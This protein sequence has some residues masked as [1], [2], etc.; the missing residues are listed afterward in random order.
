MK[1]FEEGIIKLLYMTAA[2]DG[3]LHPNEL[4]S[5]KQKLVTYPWLRTITTTRREKIVSELM[6]NNYNKKPESEILAEINNIIPDEL[7]ATAYALALEICAKDDVMHKDE[8]AFMKKL[9]KLFKLDDETIQ[10]LKKSIDI[11]YFAKQLND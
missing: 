3:E 11:R 4:D 6:E 9:A 8:M 5:I 2:C 10:S 1:R 7:K